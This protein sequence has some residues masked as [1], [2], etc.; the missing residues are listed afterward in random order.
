MVQT[1]APHPDRDRCPRFWKVGRLWGLLLLSLALVLPT[2]P[3][4]AETV[5]PLDFRPDGIAYS[6]WCGS[7]VVPK[8]ALSAVHGATGGAQGDLGHP[9]SAATGSGAN[10]SQSFERGSIYSSPRGTFAVAGFVASTYGAAGG[11]ASALGSPVADVVVEA[12]GAARYQ[13]FERGTIYSGPRGTY[14]VTGAVAQ[15]VDLQPAGKLGYAVGA[16]SRESA[17]RGSQLFERGYVFTGPSG[18]FAV[19]N[20]PGLTAYSQRG[21]STGELGLPVA[22]S[23]WNGT[24]ERQRFERGVIDSGPAGA[25]VRVPRAYSDPY[26]ESINRA[27]ARVGCAGTTIEIVDSI[28]GAAGLAYPWKGQITIARGLPAYYISYVAA[29]ECAHMLQLWNTGG[30]WSEVVAR[31]NQIYGGTGYQGLE[32]NA[33]CIAAVLG[34]PEGGYTRNCSGQRW[35]A[36]EA[37]LAG[38]MP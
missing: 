8:G 15:A 29:H 28:Q 13:R 14:A 23:L 21:G 38:R 6:S 3:A 26:A 12:G 1:S 25:W 37:V 34:F 24:A 19:L 33:D 36:A 16:F 17:Q 31:M 32:Q 27:L 18:I 5:A 11:Q 4:S 10:R 30:Q 20:G 9:C 2:T 7:H 35:T 22:N